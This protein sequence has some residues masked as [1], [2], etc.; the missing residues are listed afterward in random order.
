MGRVPY[1]P[2]LFCPWPTALRMGLID[3]LCAPCA[4]DTVVAKVPKRSPKMST[5]TQKR[6]RV[7]QKTRRW[8]RGEAFPRARTPL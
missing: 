6:R 2:S 5:C 7:A 3:V 8:G 4:A 1:S